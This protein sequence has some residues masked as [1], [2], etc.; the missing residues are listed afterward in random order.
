MTLNAIETRRRRRGS[1][2]VE[3]ALIMPIVL[4]FLI[5]A[6][7]VGR[8]VWSYNVIAEAAREGGRYAIVHGALASTK[9]GPSDN[10][11]DVEQVVRRYCVGVDPSRITVRSRWTNT[12]NSRGSTVRVQAEY[13][14]VPVVAA[15][16]GRGSVRMSSTSQMMIS[17]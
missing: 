16:A 3:A 11:A 1:T 10:D 15:I 17:H 12:D 6:L 5:G 14:Y 4:L 7:D 9:A 2:L 13:Q 8:A